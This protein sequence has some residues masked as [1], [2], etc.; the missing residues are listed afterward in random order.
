[1][2]ARQR[3][4]LSLLARGRSSS[5]CVESVQTEPGRA[6][7]AMSIYR[8]W[9]N[10]QKQGMTMSDSPPTKGPALPLPERWKAH[11]RF[12]RLLF[13]AIARLG[14]QGFLV[15]PSESVELIYDFFL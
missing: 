9:S 7:T 14:R 13:R 1:M 6:A 11:A 4:F 3:R 8:R 5:A 2:N 12:E 10:P 15:P